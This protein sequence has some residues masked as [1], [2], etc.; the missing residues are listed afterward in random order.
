M[1]RHATIP[2]DPYRPNATPEAAARAFLHRMAL[3]RSVREFSDR[4]VSRAAIE[5]IVAAAN[6]APSGANKA[7]WRFVA[8]CDPEVKRRIRAAA[9]EEERK[10]YGGRANEEWLRDLAPLGTDP[11]K[12]F[13]EVAPWLIVVFKVM[14]D[15]RSDRASD[16]VYYVNESV[17]IATGLLIAAIH[18]AGL[19]TL[20]HTPSPMRFLSEVLGRPEH[21]RPYLL[22]PV[23]HPAD[24]ARVP[25]IRRKR[26]D[27]VLVVV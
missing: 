19:V 25:D 9:E 10:F 20:T 24:D 4:P 16:Q 2:F 15:E 11:D 18:H 7:P 1:L 14:R 22:L 26:L 21:E 6:T 27:D 8:V 23:G 3:R 17:G 13:L 5:S 12:S